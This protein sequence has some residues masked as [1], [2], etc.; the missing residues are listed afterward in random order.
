MAI[1]QGT[2]TD[3]TEFDSSIGRGSPFEFTLGEGQVI[4]GGLRARGRCWGGHSSHSD[5][6]RC[7]VVVAAFGKGGDGQFFRCSRLHFVLKGS[8]ELVM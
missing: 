6:E 4:K 5:T 3:G 8:A 7:S 2:L 1:L